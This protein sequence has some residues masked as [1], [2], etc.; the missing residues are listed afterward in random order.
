MQLIESLP[1]LRE[2]LMN[3]RRAPLRPVYWIFSSLDEE[4]EEEN[5]V[6]D[7]RFFYAKSLMRRGGG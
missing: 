7:E 3:T 4:E 1:H 2:L 5:L 6:A